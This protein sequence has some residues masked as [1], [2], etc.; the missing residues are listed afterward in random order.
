M[1]NRNPN[2]GC[3]SYIHGNQI[4]PGYRYMGKMTIHYPLCPAGIQIAGSASENIMFHLQTGAGAES[5]EV[6]SG[7]YARICFWEVAEVHQGG[8]CRSGIAVCPFIY[9]EIHWFP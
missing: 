1:F 7:E 3:R 2:P 6:E 8:C 5:N 9:S 4:Y